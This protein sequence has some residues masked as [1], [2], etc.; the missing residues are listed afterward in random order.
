MFNH[1]ISHPKFM[2]T[3]FLLLYLH[4]K[5]ILLDLQVIIISL[6]HQQ[7]IPAYSLMESAICQSLCFYYIRNILRLFFHGIS[8]LPFILPLLHQ[9][10]YFD[11]PLLEP[12]IRHSLYFYYLSN[13]LRLS[14]HRISNLSLIILL[15]HPQY[16]PS[17]LSWNQQ[18][19]THYTSIVSTIY[20]AYPSMNQ[21]STT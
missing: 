9:Q 11:Y 19:V 4:L 17:T 10:L 7:Y 13:I 20:S 3:Y 18:F 8:N 14:S 5:K 2:I 12:S 15:L 6:S 21:L 16:I 1:R